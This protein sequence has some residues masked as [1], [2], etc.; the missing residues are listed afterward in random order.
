MYSGQHSLTVFTDVV[1]SVLQAPFK[2][3]FDKCW[4]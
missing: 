1:D 4:A 2:N 3:Y